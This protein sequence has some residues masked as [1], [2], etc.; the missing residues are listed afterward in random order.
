MFFLQKLLFMFDFSALKQTEFRQYFI[1]SWFS[2]LAVWM[3]RFMFGLLIWQ[4]TESF[5]WVGII[6]AALL[7]PTLIITPIFGVVSDRIDLRKGM[8]VWLSSQA[9]ISFVTFVLYWI[10]EPSL[11]VLLVI[12]FVFGC[13]ASAGSP[14]RL[15]LIP[16]LVPKDVLP[17]AVG[18]GAMI[19]NL[20]RVLSPAMAAVLLT[21]I[22]PEY[23]FFI[24]GLL[25]SAAVLF[26]SKLS[27]LPPEKRETKQ[28]KL[29]DLI[30]GFSFAYRS[31]FI[32]LMLL[33]T[34]INSQVGRALL[35]LLPAL[36]GTFT[37]GQPE[38]L[39]LLTACSGAG[40]IFG[41]LFISRQN[42]DKQRLMRLI[43]FAMMGTALAIVPIL[44]TP[45]IVILSSLVCLISLLMTVVGAGSQILIQLSTHDGIR[46]RVMSIWIM[47]ALGGP[48]VG[49]FLMGSVA[50][51]I[52]FNLMLVIMLS[53]ASFGAI[54]LGY[55]RKTVLLEEGV[56]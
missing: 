1:A 33:M 31:E 39:A 3:G 40:S 6:S 55:K 36:S 23:I 17:N 12:A 56:N 26:N 34:L 30:K 24:S 11:V 28:G 16:R 47:I 5:F 8:L 49:A 53:L 50:E 18:L 41:A 54:W 21:I 10:H 20:S 52:G 38:D 27:P 7:L 45:P 44:F 4:K 37:E 48:A 22:A 2:T 43:M 32:F 35:E 15:S 29:D 19:F 25:F 42:G 13:V 46:G 14:L 9:F 51:F